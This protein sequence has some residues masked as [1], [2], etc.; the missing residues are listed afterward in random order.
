MYAGGT[1]GVSF[2]ENVRLEPV[3]IAGFNQAYRTV[4]SESIAGSV[5]APVYDIWGLSAEGML[6]TRTWWGA[7]VNVIEQEVDHTR[8]IFTG[9]ES[10]VFPNNPAY[11]A[12]GMAEHLEYEEQSFS[13]TLNQLLGDQFSVGAGFRVTNSS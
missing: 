2:D 1:G 5:E 3:Q 11:F 7:S 12:D 9:Y 4:L 10:S 13:F 8:G 6:T